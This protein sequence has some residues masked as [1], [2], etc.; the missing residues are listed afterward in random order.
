MR[1]HAVRTS[2]IVRLA[3]PR[4]ASQIS[5]GGVRRTRAPEVRVVDRR[6]GSD[7]DRRVAARDRRIGIALLIHSSIT[8]TPRRRPSRTARAGWITPRIHPA[9]YRRP[10]ASGAGTLEG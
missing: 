3:P 8:P 9:R 5:R 7:A 10:I 1:A 4:L 6:A 2:W